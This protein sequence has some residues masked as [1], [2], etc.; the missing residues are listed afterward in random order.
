MNYSL[1]LTGSQY[2]NL[3][4]HLLPEDGKEAVAIIFCYPCQGETSFKFIANEIICIPYDD[5]SRSAIHIDWDFRKFFS[6]ERKQYLDKNKLSILKIHSHPGGFNKFS[7]TDDK[8]DERIFSSVNAWFDN[9]RPNGSLVF[10]NDGRIIG[11]VVD[12]QGGFIPMKKI[13]V[14]GDSISV[15][16]QVKKAISADYSRRIEQTFGKGTLNTLKNLKVGV[17]GCSG[18]GSVV[19]ELLARNCVGELLLIDKDVV[20]DKNLNRILNSQEEDAQ[21]GRAK[22]LVLKRAIEKMGLGTKV[23]CIESATYDPG[24][25]HK[26]KECDIIFGCVDANGVEARHHLDI[27]SCCY[28]IPYFEVGVK[29]DVEAPGGKIEQAIAMAR[30]ISPEGPYLFDMRGY[31]SDELTAEETR[32]TDPKRY[33]RE[34]KDGYLS[35]VQED[36]PAVISL[37]MQAAC[38]SVNDFLARLHGY[39]LDPNSKFTAQSLSLTQGHYR[40]SEKEPNEKSFFKKHFAK[41]DTSSKMLNR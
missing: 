11:R 5:C 4:N 22:V 41:G 40:N 14:A 3:K 16:S 15:Y 21:L 25:L 10:L 9:D 6:P 18:T 2:D 32:R 28:L 13:S 26:L 24:I 33:E 8:N 19:A 38:L 29:L 34:R 23:S 36:Q 17:V 35:A 20:E 1:S 27:M 37:N 39:R 12:S 30:Y 31:D 7:S